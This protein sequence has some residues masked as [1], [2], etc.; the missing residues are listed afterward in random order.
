[1]Y[2]INYRRSDNHIEFID[3]KDGMVKILVDDISS[4]PEV[5]PNGL[6]AI[7]LSP[8]EWEAL[9]SL[10][11]F[12]LQTGENTKLIEPDED[13]FVPK[14]AIWINDSHIAY[15]YA[16]AYGTIS[17]GGNVYIYNIDEGNTHKVTDWDSRTQAVKIEYDG[18]VLKYEGV[19]YVDESMNET[20]EIKGELDIQ[21]YIS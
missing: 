21:L 2:D 5:S 20:K 3:G 7:Y 11:L 13:S 19:N 4:K 10:Y 17:D 6:K 16:F 9:T 8:Y 12:N 1:M 18:N 15:T 14:Y